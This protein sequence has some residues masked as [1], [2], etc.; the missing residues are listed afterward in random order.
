VRLVF[1]SVGRSVQVLKSS[2]AHDLL[3]YERAAKSILEFSLDSI[4]IQRCEV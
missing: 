1:N 3:V 2:R 4:E